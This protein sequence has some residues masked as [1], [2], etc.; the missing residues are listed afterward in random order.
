[1]LGHVADTKFTPGRGYYSTPQSVSLTSATPGTT[2]RYTTNGSTPTLT[3]GLTYT[4]PLTVDK[5]T[6]IRAAGFLDGY[7][8]TKSIEAVKKLIPNLQ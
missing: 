3:N 2:I 4:D 5:T 6:V 7:E 8:P 1:M